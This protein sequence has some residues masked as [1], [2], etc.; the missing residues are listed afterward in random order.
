MIGI[1]NMEKKCSICGNVLPISEY[2]VRGVHIS[3]FC[4]QCRREKN[5]LHSA[6]YRTENKE[7]ILIKDREYRTNFR[8]LKGVKQR[9]KKYKSY[10]V[11]INICP[12]TGKYFTARHPNTKYS[13]EGAYL[14]GLMQGRESS[15]RRYKGKGRYRTC[16]ICNRE[17]D[18]FNGYRKCCSEVCQL[19]D[20]RRIRS[21]NKQERNNKVGRDHRER[22][23]YYGVLYESVDK[24]KVFNRDKWH[25]KQCGCS[26]PQSLKGS[27]KDNAPELDHIIPLSK[28]GPHTY[29]NTQLLCRS[30]N[31]N[32]SDKLIGQQIIMFDIGTPPK[33]AQEIG[34]E[35]GV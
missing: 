21:K 15:L 19:E 29:S 17:Y 13:K 10:S 30:C 35:I 32:K 25:C 14:K 12:I 11:Y 22:A 3:T 24:I 33:I 9:E 6:K 28:G 8:R 20:K 27:Y 5:K 7:A 4:K 31:L 1:I 2:D 18:L 16:V 34:H 26:T 23:M